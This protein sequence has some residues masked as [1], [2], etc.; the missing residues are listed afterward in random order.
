MISVLSKLLSTEFGYAVTFVSLPPSNPERL[1][2][3]E[4]SSALPTQTS[5]GA[6]PFLIYYLGG[7][8]HSDGRLYWKP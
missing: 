6:N 1:L 3:D 4:I 5:N 8:S 2:A 7:G